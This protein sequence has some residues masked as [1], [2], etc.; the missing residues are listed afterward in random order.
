MINA[1]PHV[2]ESV[3]DMYSEEVPS[4]VQILRILYP[5]LKLKLICPIARQSFWSD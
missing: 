5:T 3:M 2:L 4:R 1:S